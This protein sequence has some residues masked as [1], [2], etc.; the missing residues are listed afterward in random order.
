MPFSYVGQLVCNIACVFY[1]V[2]LVVV[3]FTPPQTTNSSEAA[4]GN[5]ILCT[6]VSE[7]IAV[8]FVH[9]LI[10]VCLYEQQGDSTP[11]SEEPINP[12][13]PTEPD[14]NQPTTDDFENCKQLDESLTLSWTVNKS[15]D[16]VLF[17]LCG[18]TSADTD[19]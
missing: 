10:E 18:C 5:K 12:T 14:E 13:T 3:L 4:D 17:M 8:Y 19:Q 1:G 16:S 15:A 11:T 7:I 2:H 9:V 6:G